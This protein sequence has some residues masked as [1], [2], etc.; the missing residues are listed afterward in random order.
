MGFHDH[1]PLNVQ[2]DAFNS[3]HKFETV[4]SLMS[5]DGKKQTNKKKKQK[6]KK[7]KNP[8]LTPLTVN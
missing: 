6:K 4:R 5:W 7:K 8:H 2:C 1:S 3:G